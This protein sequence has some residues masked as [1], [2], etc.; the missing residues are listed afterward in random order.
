MSQNSNLFVLMAKGVGSLDIAYGTHTSLPLFSIY[1]N[2]VII[3]SL[4]TELSKFKEINDQWKL[5]VRM[6]VHVCVCVCMLLYTSMINNNTVAP[7]YTVVD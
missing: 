4:F 5:E 7:V 6:I 1:H 2:D 3:M